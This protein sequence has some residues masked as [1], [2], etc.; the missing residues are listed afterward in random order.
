MEQIR[1]LAINPGSTSTKIAVYHNENPIFVKNIKHSLDELEQF[2]NIADQLPF[3]KK[4]IVDELFMNAVRYGSTEDKSLVYI[5]FLFDENEIQFT[6]ED[7][8]TG[9][10]AISVEELKNIIQKN[11]K[12]TDLTRTSGRGLSIRNPRAPV[13]PDC[14]RRPA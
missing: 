4:L 8:G 2:E 5:T 7:D 13:S 3:R 10:N 12:S 11:E 6:I 14:R 1:I 9:T